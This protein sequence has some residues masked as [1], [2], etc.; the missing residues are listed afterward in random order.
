MCFVMVTTI[1]GA[2]ALMRD[3][4]LPW[5][6]SPIAAERTRGVLDVGLTVFML[7]CLAVVVFDATRKWSNYETYYEA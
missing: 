3:Q 2:I 6:H 1:S 7:A 4:F 5:T